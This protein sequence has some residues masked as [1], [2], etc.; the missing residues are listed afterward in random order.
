[1]GHAGLRWQ[2]L[3]AGLLVGGQH[4]LVIVQQLALPPPLVKIKD[5]A[6]F[7]PQTQDRAER[8]SSDAAKARIASAWSQRQMVLSLMVA[9][10]PDC[11][12]CCAT[13]SR[14]ATY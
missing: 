8:S 13:S 6:G 14:L 10:N 7:K 3:D 9:T 2:R 4:E 5:A 11:R 1:M 12:A